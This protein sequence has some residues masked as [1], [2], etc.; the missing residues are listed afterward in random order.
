MTQ[1]LRIGIL[2]CARIV[3]RAIAGA[4]AKSQLA[5]WHAIAGRDGNVAAQWAAEFG[6]PR[7]YGNYEALIADP[8]VDAVY[9]PLPNE[10]HRPWALRAAAAGKHVLCEKPLALDIADAEGIVHGCRA[11]GVVLMEAFMWRHH[12]RVALA[13]KLLAEGKLG[14]LSYVKMDF[15]F[16]IDH[17]DWRLDAARGGGALFDL[18]CYGINISRL[19]TGAEPSE[20]HA[21]AR[22]LKPGVDM[23]LG[24][25]LHF[26]G[27]V[28]ALLDASF[29]CPNRNRL[30]LVGTQG[31]LEFPGGVLPEETSTLV[32]RTDAGTE[33]LSIPAADQYAEMFDCFARSV[34]AK[35]IEAPAEDG[36]ANMR[37][38]QAVRDT[39]RR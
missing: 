12:P 31:S 39:A 32:Y 9:I 24:M 23:S 14:A 15:S 30:E 16:V 33:T 4:L 20:I 10:L 13:R 1:P 7:H 21:R 8:D 28:I 37:V 18:G 26:P 22:Y 38:V 6:V 36:L 2:G 3:R 11:A 19:F 5:S 34:A 25:Q 35:R 17:A 27:D 29:E